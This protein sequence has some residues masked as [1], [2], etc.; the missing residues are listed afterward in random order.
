MQRRPFEPEMEQFRDSARKFFQQEIRPHSES[1]RE[2]NIVDREAFRKAGAQGYLCMWADEQYGGLGLKDFRYEQ[3]LIEENTLHGDR[4]YFITLHSRLVGPYIEHFG[5]AEQ[6][7]RLLPGMISG[8]TILA[9]AMT[10]PDA[11]SDLA[12]MKTRAVEQ[13]DHWLLNGSKTYI[14]N[15]INAD[16]VIVAARTHAENPHG[17]TLFLVERGMLGFERGRNLQK[18]GLKSQDTAELFFHDVRVPK[19]N[20]LGQVHGGFYH[21]M[22]GLAEERLIAACSSV[23]AARLALEL[24]RDFVRER[25]V[26]GKPLSKL[27]NTRFKLAALDAEID[28][29]Q[30]YV[31][32]CVEAHLQGQLDAV[33]ASRAKL[34]ASE[35]FGRM[36][37]EG[38]QLHGGAGYMEEY[39][40]CRLYQDERVGRILAGTSEI[41]KEIIARSLLD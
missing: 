30:V 20:V 13:D 28:I 7:Q 21:L 36:V 25:K 24:T 15:G 23:A 27:Q 39:E 14:S 12:G 41:M 9:I 32:R 26:F 37:D 35:V 29:A 8:E 34:Y 31:D 18:M 10:E 3:I 6:K 11:G 1:W 19:A 17:V 16:V 5:N 2:A 4:G 40:I 22:Q 38:V 33:D